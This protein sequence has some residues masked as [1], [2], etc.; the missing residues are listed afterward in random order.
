MLLALFF[1]TALKAQIVTASISGPANVC[2]NQQNVAYSS[3]T[4]FSG[5]TYDVEFVCGGLGTFPNGS[6]SYIINGT[7]NSN[8]CTVNW[9]NYNNTQSW[10]R[11]TYHWYVLGIH[12]TASKTINV[13]IGLG[14]VTPNAITAPASICTNNMSPFVVSCPNPLPTYAIGYEWSATN[15]SATN[16]YSSSSVITPYTSNPITVSVKFI[17]SCPFD[18]GGN[19]IYSNPY[20]YTIGR[21]S[22]TPAPSGFYY[23]WVI[24][25]GASPGSWDVTVNFPN[26]P[27]YSY[28][29]QCAVTVRGTTNYTG[30]NA[31]S[32][33]FTMRNTNALD[34]T[35]NFNDNCG[36]VNSKTDHMLMN[37][38]NLVTPSSRKAINGTETPGGDGS[39]EIG[40][41]PN[42][43]KDQLNIQYYSL[44]NSLISV[45]MTD[46]L[47][48]TVLKEDRTLEEGNNDIKLFLNELESGMAIHQA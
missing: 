42:P 31:G 45:S 43:A 34:V 9:G 3:S 39:L 35:V 47:G 21:T 40:V 16:N 13:T 46:V 23:T 14:L 38:G 36:G 37:N 1:G 2:P 6:T 19:F 33:T 27:G 32:A 4:N 15:S 20:S 22:P 29:W 11:V 24:V 26:A 18:A 41:F 28:T 5:P 8:S 12:Y 30:T 7:D 10:V 44:E 25:P 17:T 48:K